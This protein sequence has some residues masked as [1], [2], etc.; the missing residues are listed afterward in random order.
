ML[1]IGQM[2]VVII[3]TMIISYLIIDFIEW[4]KNTEEIEK[5]EWKHK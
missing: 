4:L 1:T 3:C 2:T 5:E